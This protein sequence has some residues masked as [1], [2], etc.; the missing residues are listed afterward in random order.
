MKRDYAQPATPFTLMGWLRYLLGSTKPVQSAN[1]H[2]L[3]IADRCLP[4]DSRLRG[5]RNEA[6]AV[7]VSEI[8]ALLRNGS[9]P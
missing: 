9:T 6:P 4:H 5:L 3:L 2:G 8:K 7:S 1:H